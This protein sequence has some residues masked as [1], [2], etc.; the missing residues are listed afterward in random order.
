M[1][2][3]PLRVCHSRLFPGAETAVLWVLSRNMTRLPEEANR[4]CLGYV[5]FLSQIQEGSGVTV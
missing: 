4:T 2:G 5:L 3:I 1:P